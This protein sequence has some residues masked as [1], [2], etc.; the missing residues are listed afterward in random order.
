MYLHTLVLAAVIGVVGWF[1]REPALKLWFSRLLVGAHVVYVALDFAHSDSV[2]GNGLYEGDA[3]VVPGFMGLVVLLLF[4][5]PSVRREPWAVPEPAADA[6]P[7]AADGTHT[8]AAGH[9]G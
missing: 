2:L 7:P 3:S 6:N 8:P 4:L 1:A 5:G 9:R